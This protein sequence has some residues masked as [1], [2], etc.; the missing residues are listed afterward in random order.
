VVDKLGLSYHNSRELN[1]IIDE[2]MPGRPKFKC[3]ELRI[4]GE[5]YEFHF[6][7][8]IPCL[9]ALFGD[10]RF[11][12]HLALAPERHYQDAGHTTQVFSEMYTG[13]WWWSVQ[14][15]MHSSLHTFRVLMMS[16]A[17]PG[18]TQAG[19][20]CDTSHHLIGQDSAHNFSIQER[21]SCLLDNRQHSES[22]S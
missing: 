20:D 17:L 15:R 4:G 10:P 12:K 8:T 1:R 6:R 2:Q 16:S 19:C 22:H 5:S 18:V 3:E 13:K 9:R 14:V 21:I 7:E 11:S